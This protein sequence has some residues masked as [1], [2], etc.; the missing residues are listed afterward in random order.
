MGLA[1]ARNRARATEDEAAGKGRR[2]ARSD[3]DK[4]AINSVLRAFDVLFLFTES[5]SG[6]IGVTEIADQLGVSKTGVFR[7]LTSLRLRGMVEL[8]E[9]THRYLLGP[10]VLALGEAFRSRLDLRALC[11]PEM[12]GLMRDTDETATLSIRHGCVRTYIDQVTPN[13]DVKM[14][15]RIGHEY[16]LHAGASSKAFLAFIPE[17]EQRECMSSLRSLTPST[18][19][20]QRALRTELAGIR[21]RGYAISLGER[22]PSAG[23]VAAPVF[24][25]GSSVPVAVMSVCGPVE[26]FKEETD[27]ISGLLLASVAR[28][29]AR[30][31]HTT[32]AA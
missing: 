25:A 6:T 14:I 22:D 24:A 23:S 4:E 5:D 13:R 30:L 27:K 29:S 19:T 12:E 10:R 15:V 32:G 8:D 28:V 20:S 26:R 9:A 18:I 2:A 7:I 21:E 3:P 1:M 17:A 31:G 16:P 11:Q